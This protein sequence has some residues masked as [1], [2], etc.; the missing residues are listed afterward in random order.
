MVEYMAHARACYEEVGSRMTAKHLYHLCNGYMYT[1][2]PEVEPDE[3]A[4]R[5]AAQTE[6]VDAC[7]ER[8]TTYFEAV[9][10]GIIENRLAELKNAA[11]PGQEPSRS[12]ILSRFLPADARLRIRTPTLVYGTTRA[13]TR[14]AR[15]IRSV[16]RPAA[17]RSQHV[18]TGH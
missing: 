2:A 11:P 17:T 1:R 9:Q 6:R 7:T 10:R 12:R 5:H 4:R 15:G 14:L 13:P 16:D 8:G 18:L 3:L